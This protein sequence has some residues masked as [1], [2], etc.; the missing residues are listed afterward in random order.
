M[1]LTAVRFIH[2]DYR[3]VKFLW[4]LLVAA[5]ASAQTPSLSYSTYFGGDGTDVITSV[6][7]DSTGNVYVCG[8]TYSSNLPVTSGA[9]QSKHGGMPGT[10]FSIFQSPPLPDAFVAK[11]DQS[12]SLIYGTYLGGVDYDAAIAIA[13]DASGAAIVAGQTSSLNFP[14]TPGALKTAIP[15]AGL[16]TI[17]VAKFKPDGSALEFATYFGGRGDTVKSLALDGTGNIYMT[18]GAVSTDFPK[19]PGAVGQDLPGGAFAAKLSADG[20]SL[21]Y[22]G[23]LGGAMGDLGTGIAVD[24]AGN[25]YVAGVT[26][27][28]SF[29]VTPDAFQKTSTAHTTGFVSKLSPDASMLLNSTLLGGSGTSVP[30]GRIAVSDAGELTLTGATV[31]A[32]FP[33]SDRA[34]QPMLAGEENAFLT[35][36]NATLSGLVFS[37]Y[38]GGSNV[39]EGRGVAQDPSGNLWVTGLSNSTDFPI[40]TPEIT[41]AFAGSP[42][43]STG[44]SPF[45]MPPLSRSCFDTFIAQFSGTG[46]LLYSST[47]SG[48]NDET[49]QDVTVATSSDVLVAGSSRSNDFPVTSD[50]FQH[51]RVAATCLTVNSP[52]STDSQPCDDGFLSRIGIASEPVPRL[53][54][55]NSAGYLA[56]AVAPNEIV[57]IFGAGIGPV[58]PAPAAIHVPSPIAT[59]LAG[60]QVKFN[61]TAAPL[62]YASRNQINAIVPNIAAGDDVMVTIEHN[63]AEFA[64]S[65]IASAPVAPGIPLQQDG[66]RG[67]AAVINHDGTLNSATNPAGAGSVVSLFVFGVSPSATAGTFATAATPLAAPPVVVVDNLV[68][69]IRYAGSAPGLITAVSQI[70]FVVPQL[71]AGTH[72]IY[73]VINGYSSPFGAIL[74]MH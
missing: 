62:L 50:A 8:F 14:V 3:T 21:M 13:V 41:R 16:P 49:P 33:V 19:T 23:I 4:T 60:Y 38:L 40:T 30:A 45:G 2:Q 57:T 74:A 61:G 67:E 52:S 71:A 58:N 24:T 53:V 28:S 6:A 35:R 64:S 1:V 63:G 26:T 51:A 43:I 10:V 54:V 34:Y 18:G 17:F 59:E 20:S 27:S 7:T 15:G 11:F 47:L 29:P 72:P 46:A 22:A 36:L 70:N 32:D 56:S 48:G 5:L 44:G 9:F 25:A 12:G 39:D 73:I 42:C 65:T 69:D 31:D 66:I 55:V 37:T 68:A